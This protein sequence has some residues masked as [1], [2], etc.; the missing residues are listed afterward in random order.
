MTKENN[1]DHSTEI[2]PNKWHNRSVSFEQYEKILK[3]YKHLLLY[4]SQQMR[5]CKKWY[6]EAFTK[7]PNS[8]SSYKK[9]KDFEIHESRNYA[10]SLADD[11]DNYCNKKLAKIDEIAEEFGYDIPELGGKDE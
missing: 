6:D 3:S 7:Y 2:T 10:I 9:L 1:V 11:F 4:S 8:N 5:R